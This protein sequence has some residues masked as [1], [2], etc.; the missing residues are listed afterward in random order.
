MPISNSTGGA[1]NVG[2]DC[3]LVIIGAGT[4][5]RVDLSNVTGFECDPE[6]A[7][8]KVDRLDGVQ[9]FQRLPK[10]WRG[11]F[12]MERGDASADSLQNALE[13][14]WY[15][16]GT[17]TTGI[18]YQYINEVNGSQTTYSYQGAVIW[19]EKA[20]RWQGDAT[21]KQRVGMWAQRRVTVGL[22]AA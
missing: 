20:G 13:L 9:L 18:V 4:L 5:G 11:G 17:L 12:D 3:Q 8:V 19:L 21:V 14:A 2:L 22:V 15:G 7:D 10:G 16:T 1:F 6:F